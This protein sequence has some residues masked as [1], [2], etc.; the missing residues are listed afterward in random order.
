VSSNW[1]RP[2]K[3]HSCMFF[4]KFHSKPYYITYTNKR[5][6]TTLVRQLPI[7]VNLKLPE[8]RTEF[9]WTI[10][11]DHIAWNLRRNHRS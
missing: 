6:I 4:P 5:D 1:T 8:T 10:L 9:G 2:W 7:R 3:T 11:N